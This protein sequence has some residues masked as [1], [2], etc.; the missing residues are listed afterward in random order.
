MDSENSHAV[1]DLPTRLASLCLTACSLP[2]LA[3]FAYFAA[4]HEGFNFLAKNVASLH[5][6]KTCRF[7][8]HG[9]NSQLDQFCNSH[10]L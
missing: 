1:S 6:G 2:S 9:N 7:E 3:W 8:F 4:L 10:K 5:E